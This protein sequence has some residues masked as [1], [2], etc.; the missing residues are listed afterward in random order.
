[1]RGVTAI[2]LAAI[3]LFT[4]VG[5][6]RWALDRQMEELCK[7]DGGIK[8][9]ETVTL[10]ASSYNRALRSGPLMPVAEDSWFVRIGPADDYRHYTHREYIVGKGARHERGEGSLSRVHES[11]YRWPEKRLL[12]ESVRYSRGG[13][14]G[15]TFGF[16]P[17]GASCPHLTQDLTQSIFVK[18]N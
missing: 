16:Q 18:G 3:L 14:D 12:G 8:V 2:P 4:L 15:F 5:C 7:K 11:I 1:M 17:S 6:E 13:G 10:P 9:Y